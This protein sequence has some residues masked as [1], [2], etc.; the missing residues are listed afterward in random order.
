MKHF[1]LKP[2]NA[3]L[4]KMAAFTLL[5]PFL[6][7]FNYGLNGQ[8]LSL[9]CNDPDPAFPFE[10]A[11]NEFCESVLTPDAVLEAPQLCPGDKLIT[12]RDD[13]N[14]IV[15]VDTNLV[16]FDANLYLGMTMSVMVQDIESGIFCVSFIRLVD[17]LPPML[18]C[19]DTTIMC[20]ADTSAAML[21]FPLV[22]DN[23]DASPSLTFRDSI[24]L[25]D[26]SSGIITTIFRIWTATDSSGNNDQCVQRI[27]LVRPALD[28]IV[29]PKHDTVS[30]DNPIIIPDSTG[31]PTLGGVVVE[32]GG[33][34]DI[35]VGYSDQE[36][37]LCGN[38]ERQI[39]RHWAITDN[40][41]GETLHHEQFILILDETVPTLI[42]PQP[43]TVETNSGDCSATVTLPLPQVSDNCDV[44]PEIFITTSYGAVGQGP[45]P[46]VPVGTH[47][48]QYTAVDEC[49]NISRCSTTLNV[50]DNEVPTA[51][52]EDFLIVSAPADGRAMVFAPSFDDG[53]HDNCA[54]RVYFKVK[55][56]VTGTCGGANG[57]D[58]N[59]AGYQEW[60]D[61]KVI[62]CCEETNASDLVVQFRVYEVDPGPGPVNPSR[63]APGGDLYGHWAECTVGV[64]IQDKLAPTLT[65]PHDTVID[66]TTDYS[67]L[68]VFGQPH[69]KDNCNGIITLD[70]S[71]IV[72]INGC[73]TGRITRTYTA[74]DVNGNS[75][76]CTQIIDVINQNPFSTEDI[77]WPQNYVTNVC[78]AGVDPD[79]LPDG[80]DRPDLL[81]ESCSTIGIRYEDFLYDLSYPAC[82]KILRTWTIIDWCRYNPDDA[83]S[84]GKFI[85]TQTI[86]V[87]DEEKP[88]MTCPTPIEVAVGS[89]C[90]G[91]NVTIPLVTA[92]D[93]SPHVIITNDSPYASAAGADASGTYPLGTTVVTFV[94][95]DRCGN[96]ASCKVTITVKDKTPPSALCLAGLSA[97]I[98]SDKMAHVTAQGFNAGSTDNCTAKDKIKHFIR[99]AVQSPAGPPSTTELTFTC[100]EVGMQLIEFW[101]VDEAG[102]AD[103]CVTFI[104]IQDNRNLCA[105]PAPTLGAIAGEIYT[106]KGKRVEDVMV[107]I[108]NVNSFQM[109]TTYDGSFT[110]ANVPLG[111]NYKVI[112]QKNSDPLNGVST[113]DLVLIAKHILGVEP[114]DSPYKIIAADVD[115][116]GTISVRD[117]IL[118]RKMILGV[119]PDMPDGNA[120]WRFIDARYEFPDPANPFVAVFPESYLV[121]GFNKDER[122]INFVAVKIGDVNYSAITNNLAEINPRSTNGDWTLWAQD[123]ELHSGQE[124]SVALQ[125]DNTLALD[126]LQFALQF[127]PQNLEFVGFKPAEFP[128]IT[129]N[130]IGLSEIAEGNIKVSWNGQYPGMTD[131]KPVLLYLQFRGKN[132]GVSLSDALSIQPRYLIPEAYGQDGELMDLKLA[133]DPKSQFIEPANAWPDLYQNAPNPFL[134]W[135]TIRFYLPSEG[136]ATLRIMDA[137][138]KVVWSRKE[139]YA[140]GTQQIVLK[141]NELP[142][143]N[144][145]FYQ[146]EF[147]G[148]MITRKMFMLQ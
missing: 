64:T 49:G 11:V 65:C 12:V 84:P 23:C 18:V 130:N 70:S 78:G 122:F 54:E 82:Y 10:V 111:N 69:A 123:R 134:D 25:G 89:D 102:N 53:S 100:A 125:G 20:T 127:D 132:G 121:K 96:T 8:C 145:L 110:F 39:V 5:I 32:T 43:L 147:E 26:C 24:E 109:H 22:Q 31:R 73:G 46:L 17:N 91:A 28:E 101:A 126:G 6:L 61:D 81:A 16:R 66:C 35:L 75:T 29:F 40:C 48:I 105:P 115:K 80:F 60:F 86:K 36:T 19:Q 15:M 55:R 83:N 79:D 56:M 57:D 128:G 44:T 4:T 21:P 142:S 41:T 59:L 68:A 30:C 34:C 33:M 71:I 72:D 74:R 140:Q 52:C 9:A 135:T 108:D 95:K 99:K 85:F 143:S 129:E 136:T 116:S 77:K 124:F 63:E 118:L 117:L 93:C 50:I 2:L 120:S 51:V 47:T 7:M 133:F 97:S 42:C 119:L 114:L 98:D 37:A 3:K 138:G 1:F 67:N 103:Y 148:V 144:I 38:I 131:R 58:S 87:V 106:E 92:V 62:F 13:R 104:A 94:A 76:T 14:M 45:H 137:T 88:V 146:L 139:T 113:F 141:R 107:K 27:D 112:A 90:V